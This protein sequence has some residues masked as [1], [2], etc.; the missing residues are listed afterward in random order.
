MPRPSRSRSMTRPNAVG[1]GESQLLGGLRQLLGSRRIE[2]PAPDLATEDFPAERHTALLLFL[3]D[4]LADLLPRPPGL[5]VRQPIPR[6]LGLRGGQNFD[7]VAVAQRPMQ[8][9]DAAV[10]AGR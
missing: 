1:V 10:D 2:A 3:L 6:R 7:R 9:R 5:H 4:P 8:R